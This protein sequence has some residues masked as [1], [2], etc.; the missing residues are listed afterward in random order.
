M[1]CNKSRFVQTSTESQAYVFDDL[2][3][4]EVVRKDLF[5]RVVGIGACRADVCAE[6]DQMLHNA[7]AVGV[8]LE[9]RDAHRRQAIPVPALW[10]GSV[11]AADVVSARQEHLETPVQRDKR[12]S[13]QRT[14]AI[15]VLQ[16]PAASCRGVLPLTSLMST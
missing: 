7:G 6:L 5:G 9:C 1:V 16:Q 3:D 8:V 14:Y 10:P 11:V 13:T 2:V 12:I 4:G 15:G